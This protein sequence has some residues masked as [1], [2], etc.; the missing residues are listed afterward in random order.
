[1]GPPSAKPNNTATRRDA[2]KQQQP[3]LPAHAPRQRAPRQQPMR[4]SR[5][6]GKRPRGWRQGPAATGR[7]GSAIGGRPPHV[8]VSTQHP[9][10]LHPPTHVSNHPPTAPTVISSSRQ[11][12]CVLPRLGSGAAG[13]CTA[14]AAGQGRSR[15]GPPQNSRGLASRSC[16]A[17]R[18]VRQHR[19]RRAGA[20][21]R[22]ANRSEAPTWLAGAAP[23]LAAFR[24]SRILRA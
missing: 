21:Q 20:G 7:A 6:A 5:V 1:M 11:S 9:K 18:T 24:T 19:G 3:A 17:A 4:D 15:S 8:S 2:G 14:V 12:Q 13:T 16:A 23:T 22:R 10:H